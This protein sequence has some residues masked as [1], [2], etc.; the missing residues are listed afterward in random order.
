MADGD[1]TTFG[2]EQSDGG[3]GDHRVSTGKMAAEAFGQKKD[4]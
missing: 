2:I 3:Q 4:A 1:A